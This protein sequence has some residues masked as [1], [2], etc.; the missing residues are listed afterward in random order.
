M[1]KH[2]TLEDSA[3]ATGVPYEVVVDAA[4]HTFDMLDADQQVEL[5]EAA[6][7]RWSAH[8]KM[9]GAKGVV[10]AEKPNQMRDDLVYR[11]QH[12]R[13]DLIYAIAVR[14]EDAAGGAENAQWLMTPAREGETETPPARVSRAMKF[15]INELRRSRQ[16]FEAVRLQHEAQTRKR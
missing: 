3:L 10:F 14:F 5:I 15:I 7:E 11:V 6:L 13:F 2:P 9:V 12:E 8:Q 1:T 16:G 4:A